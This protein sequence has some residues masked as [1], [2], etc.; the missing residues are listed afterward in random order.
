MITGIRRVGGAVAMAAGI[1]F[2]AWLVFGPVHD[3]EGDMRLVRMAMGLA[4]MGA[5]TGGARLV[6]WAPEGD[7]A[8]AP[9][10]D[11]A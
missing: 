9:A 7:G 5:I 1:G 3:W 11:Q 4:A 2:A 6:F 10:D 8:A